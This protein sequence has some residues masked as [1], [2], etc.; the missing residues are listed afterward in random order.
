MYL[1]LVFSMRATGDTTGIMRT[2]NAELSPG[3]GWL[4]TTLAVRP[5]YNALREDWYADPS[6]T[7]LRRSDLPPA[8]LQAGT[9]RLGGGFSY[10]GEFP[11]G[12]SFMMIAHC[13][14]AMLFGYA[15]GHFAR[16]VYFR[17]LREHNAT[18]QVA[19]G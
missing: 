4:P 14:W 18:A 11:D 6:G 8:V 19:A 2:Y 9:G 3:D 7:R 10:L 15:G 16:W 13:L 12:Q 1:A 5:V 17:R